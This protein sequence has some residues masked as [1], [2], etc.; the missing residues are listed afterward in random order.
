MWY[1]DFTIGVVDDGEEH[2][3]QHEEHKEDVGEEVQRTEDVISLQILDALVTKLI[4]IA[5]PL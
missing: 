3:E 5:L 4:C 1:L 2:V